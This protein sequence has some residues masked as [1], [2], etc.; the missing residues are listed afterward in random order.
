M[1]PRCFVIRSTSKWNPAT[2]CRYAAIFIAMRTIHSI[3]IICCCTC[4]NIALTKPSVTRMPIV[5][6]W[7]TIRT[8]FITRT[9]DCTSVMFYPT[10]SHALSGMVTSNDAFIN[11]G[12]TN[13]F[14]FQFIIWISKIFVYF[15]SNQVLHLRAIGCWWFGRHCCWQCCRCTRDNFMQ[16]W[17]RVQ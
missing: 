14:T 4:F 1:A 11:E 12:I 15:C 3:W 5:W 17:R 8:F 9:I 2:S 16:I 10:I 13:V 6:L 7:T